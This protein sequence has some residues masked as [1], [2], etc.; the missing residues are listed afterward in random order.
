MIERVADLGVPF[1]G[2]ERERRYFDIACERIFRAADQG[3]I[4][5]E[6]PQ[7]IDKKGFD[8]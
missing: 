2:I 7:P 4:L 8:L 5:A 1:V 3:R 6:L